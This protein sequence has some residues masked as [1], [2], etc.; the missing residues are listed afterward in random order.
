MPIRELESDKK[1]REALKNPAKPNNNTEPSEDFT[2]YL[3]RLN[4]GYMK[5]PS[6]MK[7]EEKDDENFFCPK[8]RRATLKRAR[9]GYACSCGFYT[10]T[11][12]KHV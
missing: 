3:K 2:E 9:V 11:P 12:L 7:K 6:E 8:C 10:N 1:F 4:Y 5:K